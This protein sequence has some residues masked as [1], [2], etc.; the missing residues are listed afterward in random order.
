MVLDLANK[1]GMIC[2]RGTY[3]IEWKP[4]MGW[5]YRYW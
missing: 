2:F 1:F 4:N 3:V 5:M